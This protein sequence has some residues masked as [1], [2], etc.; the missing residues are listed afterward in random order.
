MIVAKYGNQIR[1]RVCGIWVE[2]DE[3]LLVKHAH[4][5]KKNALWLPPGGGIEFGENTKEA[6]KREFK[7]ETGVDIKV[8]D[9]LF[10][11]EF[12]QPPFHAIELFFKVTGD[13]T[14]IST[15]HDPE[16]L[17]DHQSIQHVGFVSFERIKKEIPDSL[18]GVL[19]RIDSLDEIFKQKGYFISQ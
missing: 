16:F 11:Y 12:V 9:F 14:Q 5:D 18:H 3:I 6:L 8:H 4:L 10:T 2:G 17:N 13:R 7:E 1:V 15:G 19:Q